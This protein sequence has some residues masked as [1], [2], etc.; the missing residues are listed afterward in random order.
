M[1]I[2]HLTLKGTTRSRSRTHAQAC[3]WTSWRQGD[4]C[5]AGRT[6][7]WRV[8]GKWRYTGPDL[9]PGMNGGGGE[10][11]DEAE[12]GGNGK[13]KN[14][15]KVKCSLYGGNSREWSRFLLRD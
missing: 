9:A 7:R 2:K 12:T 5:T 14:T 13:T 10:G 4:G 11:E 3:T 1:T 15:W 8:I 6:R